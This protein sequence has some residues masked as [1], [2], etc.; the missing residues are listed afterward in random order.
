MTPHKP[1]HA[2][3]GNPR[4][5]QVLSKKGDLWPSQGLQRT[6]WG[7]AALWNE[8]LGCGPGA[9]GQ[10]Y[11][12]CQWPQRVSPYLLARL[13]PG[14][15]PHFLPFA[16]KKSIPGR[17]SPCHVSQML[18]LPRTDRSLP[19]R[20]PTGKCSEQTLPVSGVATHRPY[21]APLRA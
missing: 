6:K 17:P 18:L 20:V 7:F 21:P 4:D 10:E 16:S 9:F 3:I 12:V 11:T 19:D 15:R 13:R 14:V 1:A 5:D 8:N 2:M